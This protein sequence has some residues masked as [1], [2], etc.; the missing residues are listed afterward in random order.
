VKMGFASSS[1]WREIDLMSHLWLN[2]VP[3]LSRDILMNTEFPCQ[4]H[5]R[6]FTELKILRSGPTHQR[7]PIMPVVN[8]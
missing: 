2:E 4:V 6:T 7:V 5:L 3:P 8:R 1:G